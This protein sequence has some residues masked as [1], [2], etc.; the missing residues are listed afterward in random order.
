LITT[1]LTGIF[2]CGFIE[3]PNALEGQYSCVKTS[4]YS[5]FSSSRVCRGILPLRVR[6]QSRQGGGWTPWQHAHDRNCHRTLPCTLHKITGHHR[7]SRVADCAIFAVNKWH[8]L[9]LSCVVGY[10]TA[11]SHS[12][13]YTHDFDPSLFLAHCKA[14]KS[15]TYKEL[16]IPKQCQPTPPDG[17]LMH[18]ILSISRIAVRN[19]SPG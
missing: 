17:I 9:L 15:Q 13:F 3:I 2:I 7:L 18:Y 16:K 8:Q 1:I 11:T 4:V 5:P 14:H 19:N 6:C 12:N 10:P